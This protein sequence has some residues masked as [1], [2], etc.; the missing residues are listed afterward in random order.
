MYLVL[1]GSI[2]TTVC[3]LVMAATLNTRLCSFDY[4]KYFCMAM[5]SGQ[6]GQVLA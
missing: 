4:G 3:Q 6:A 1:C 2:Y 5:A